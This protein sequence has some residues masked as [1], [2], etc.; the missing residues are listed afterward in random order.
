[1]LALTAF[2]GLS[3]CFATVSDSALCPLTLQDREALSDGLIQHP[4]TAPAVGDPA[5]SLLIT[6]SVCEA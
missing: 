6:L 2:L 1:M 4:E 5:V 3:G